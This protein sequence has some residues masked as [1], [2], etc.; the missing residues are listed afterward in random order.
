[1]F[2]ACLPLVPDGGC[3][4]FA[5]AAVAILCCGEKQFHQ[6]SNVN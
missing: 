4:H 5:S 1:M 3:I 6:L 2:L